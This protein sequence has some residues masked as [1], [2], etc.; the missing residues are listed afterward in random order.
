MYLFVPRNRLLF[1]TTTQGSNLRLVLPPHLRNH[2]PRA[3]QDI[4]PKTADLPRPHLQSG[5]LA[6][7]VETRASHHLPSRHLRS[8][9]VVFLR[10]GTH[11]HRSPSRHNLLCCTVQ[12]QLLSDR[13]NQPPPLR[14]RTHWNPPLR[15][16]SRLPRA[17]PHT[18]QQWRV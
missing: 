7:R 8:I 12:P 6:H 18:P 13:I 1:P 3:A 17:I 2:S 15:L 16:H 10:S 14:R 9:H 5:I 11:T 4:H